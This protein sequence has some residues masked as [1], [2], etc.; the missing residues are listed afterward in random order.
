MVMTAAQLQFGFL[1]LQ[2]QLLLTKS[3]AFPSHL[4][5]QVKGTLFS[6]V[7]PLPSEHTG[8]LL[9]SFSNQLIHQAP[10]T[11]QSPSKAV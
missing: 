3:G 7:L 1:F 4:L 8:I 5:T 2:L 10:P 11:N 9:Y 6:S